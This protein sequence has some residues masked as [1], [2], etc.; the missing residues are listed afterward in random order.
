[1]AP[2]FSKF[3]RVSKFLWPQILSSGAGKKQT[4]LLINNV[5]SH[6]VLH[7][8]YCLGMERPLA[9]M[10]KVKYASVKSNLCSGSDI[11][12]LPTRFQGSCIN[13]TP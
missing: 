7:S 11:L 3:N 2:V 12:R 5:L 9:I 13:A 8:L 4:G 1:M 6:S 10:Q